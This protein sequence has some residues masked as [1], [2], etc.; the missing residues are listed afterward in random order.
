MHVALRLADGWQ[1]H[2]DPSWREGWR[3]QTFDLGDGTTEVVAMGQGP[4]LLLL[5][6]LPGY[7]EAWIGVAARL[8]RR[9][10]VVTFDQRSQFRGRPTWASLLTDLERVADA[11]VPGPA[12]VVGH[13]LGGALAQRWALVHPGRI[14]A[15]VLS[16][17]FARVGRTRSQWTK[18]Y[19]E[20]TLVLAS[21]R[22]LPDRA[23]TALARSLA[24]REAWVYDRRCDERVLTFVRHAI[25]TV[26]VAVA[27]RCVRLAFEHDVRAEVG[28]IAVPV[29]LVVGERESEWARV[30]TEELAFHL[31]GAVVSVS[32]GVGHLHPLSGARWLADAIGAWVETV[33][34]AADGLAARAVE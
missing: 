26:P 21:Q 12:I 33:P 18:R 9:F 1:P 31:H 14:R 19:V 20:Q 8:A 15:L 13:S 27:A 5:P 3:P 24:A 29:L 23:A 7:K 34:R 17:S 28:S 16:S 10:R 22:W 30:A 4:S 25:R 2:V 11:F 6:P 32:P